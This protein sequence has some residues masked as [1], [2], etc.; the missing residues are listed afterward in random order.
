MVSIKPIDG[1]LK[2]DNSLCRPNARTTSIPKPRKTS[3][4]NY[5]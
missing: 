3:Y 1:Y 2:K 5:D 4:D